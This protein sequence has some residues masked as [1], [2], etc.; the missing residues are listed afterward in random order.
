MTNR[1]KIILS[2]LFVLFLLLGARYAK[3]Q[4]TTTTVVVNGNTTTTTTTTITPQSTTSI[5]N[6]PNIGDITNTTTSSMVK[7]ET[8]ATTNTSSGNLLTGNFC[9]GGWTGTQITNSPSG[10]TSDLGCNYLTGK[11]TSS[12]AENSKNLLSVGISK[13]EQNLGFTQS[14]NAQIG[15]YWYHPQGLTFSQSVTNNDTGETITQ[16]RTYSKG[17]GSDPNYMT[18][19]YLDNIIVGSN[20]A[21][22]YTSKIRFDF[23]SSG[24]GATWQGADITS[25]SLSITYTALNTSTITGTITETVIIPCESLGT[26]YTPPPPPTIEQPKLTSSGIPLDQQLMNEFTNPITNTFT[27]PTSTITMSE[28]VSITGSP[29]IQQTQSTNTALTGDPSKTE[30]TISTKSEPSTTTSITKEEQKTSTSTV[31]ESNATTTTP[32]Q[33]TSTS[34]K[35]TDSKPEQKSEEK[36]TS[37]TQSVANENKKTEG[38][39]AQTANEKTVSDT[40]TTTNEK[41]STNVSVEAK[42]KASVEKVEKELKNIGDKTRAIQEIKIEGIKAGSPNLA[43]YE[44]KQFYD[45]RQMVG[46]PN[47]DFYKQINIEQQQIYKDAS[48]SAYISKDPIAVRQRLLKEIEDEQNDIIIQIELLKKGLN[49][50]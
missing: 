45:V 34:S 7:T 5:P 18:T 50:G 12:Y 14:A 27:N 9:T 48:L 22:G 24:G 10:A 21:S 37:T 49:K 26:C 47:P 35:T 33:E 16:N 17:V 6:T 32:T 41:G 1:F 42:V 2:I 13:A 39:Q 15:F 25:P 46:V 28:P 44:N 3:A 4:S 30:T 36:Q 20:S 31:K 11:G 23:T 19:K 29:V 43:I 40:K 38:P 8:T